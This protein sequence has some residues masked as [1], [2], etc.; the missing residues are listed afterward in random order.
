MAKKI[1][2]WKI[3]GKL[4]NEKSLKNLLIQSL[5]PL[6]DGLVVYLS[7]EVTHLASTLHSNA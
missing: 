4:E 3:K 7:M 1:L 5:H 6:K 2:K